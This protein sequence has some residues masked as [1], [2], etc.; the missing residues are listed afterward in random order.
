M[1]PSDDSPPG[2]QEGDANLQYGAA[3]DRM[4]L[5]PNYYAWIAARF[6]AHV[7]G[8]VLELGCGAGHVLEHYL[9]R[10]ERVIGVDVNAELLRRLEQRHPGGRVRGIQADL[11]GDWHELEGLSADVV[12]ALD[13]LE[14]FQDDAAFVARARAHVKPRGRLVLKVPAQSKLFGPMDLASGHFRR[15]DAED[16][17]R[18][19]AGAGFRTLALRPMNPLGAWSYR[20]KR[21]QK[22][23]FSKSLSPAKLRAANALMPLFATLDLVPGLNGLSLV[24]VFERGD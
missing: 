21:E 16:L 1:S 24:G 7:H 20:F 4:A 2:A 8:T 13:V 5:L 19:L 22:T 9:E 23:N 17:A 18:L 3:Q 12:I 11:R 14:H 15:Y 10:A 6:R